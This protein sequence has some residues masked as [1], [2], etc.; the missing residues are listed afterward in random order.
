MR[1]AFQ[2]LQ[3]FRHVVIAHAR[4]KTQEPRNHMECLLVLLLQRDEA[5]PQKAVDRVFERRARALDL[6]SEK[7][8]NVAVQGNRSPHIPMFSS[9]AS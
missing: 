4:W 8:G 9:E 1:R 2:I 5:Q 7:A 6:L 3:E